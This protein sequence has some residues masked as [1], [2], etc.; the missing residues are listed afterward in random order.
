M[1]TSI[2]LDGVTKRFGDVAAVSDATL[3]VA[4]GEILALLGPSGCGKTTLLRTIAGF[5]RPDSGTVEVGGRVVAGE[6]WAPPEAPKRGYYKLYVEHVQQAD[7]GAD[8]D[9]LV[10][11]SGTT[12]T[13][14]SH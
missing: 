14:D 9:F 11:G 5:E 2:R 3:D 8:L 10:G 12:V 6:T 4:G 13:R 1:G 7:K